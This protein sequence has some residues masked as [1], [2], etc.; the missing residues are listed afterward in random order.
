VLASD[1]FRAGV[2]DTRFAEALAKTRRR[3]SAGALIG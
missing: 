3:P 1:E 2:Y